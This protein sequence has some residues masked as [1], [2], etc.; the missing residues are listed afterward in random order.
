MAFRCKSPVRTMN[1]DLPVEQAHHFDYLGCGVSYNYDSDVCVT[2][3]RVKLCDGN[4][5]S[6][7]E[8]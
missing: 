8:T 2:L 6:R 1:F 5:R 4:Q 3:R 7:R